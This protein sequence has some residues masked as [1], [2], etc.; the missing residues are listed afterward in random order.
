MSRL[1]GNPNKQTC[2]DVVMG[3]TCGE[4]AVIR[5]NS[6]KKYFCEECWDFHLEMTLVVDGGSHEKP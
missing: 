1:R 3:K 6:C 2:Q 4:L 5:C